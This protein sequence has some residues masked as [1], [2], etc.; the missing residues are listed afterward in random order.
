MGRTVKA[1]G[2]LSFN[3]KATMALLDQQGSIRASRV[4]EIAALVASGGIDQRALNI[5]VQ[6]VTQVR[7]ATRRGKCVVITCD[8]GEL[9]LNQASDIAER[10]IAEYG[11]ALGDQHSF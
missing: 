8:S 1:G 9:D 2:S 6:R 10:F 7:S 3:K 4:R 11:R 5:A